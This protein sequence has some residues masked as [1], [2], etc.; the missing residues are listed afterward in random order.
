M[1][2]LKFSAM[3][4]TLALA[5][6]AAHAAAPVFVNGGFETDAWAAGETN[7]ATPTG[8]TAVQSSDSR[9]V[10][11]IHNTGSTT[12][13]YTPFGTQF[14]ELCAVD[15]QGG[16]LGNVSQTLSGF[17]VGAQYQLDFEQSP[18]TSGAGFDHLVSVTIAGAGTTSQVFSA[19]AAAT[20]GYSWATWQHQTMTFTADSPTL[21]FTFAG[22]IST[23]GTTDVESGIDNITLKQLS[24]PSSIPTLSEWG[25]ITLSSLLAL[26][27]ILTLRRKRQ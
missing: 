23:N 7:H 25:M 22:V 5:S 18:E 11:G 21:T 19:N 4:M 8:W 16:T 2:T 20:P 13:D 24:A 14:I 15:C 9:F 26:G 6:A 10:N 12:F 17:V 3:C 27:T 1:K